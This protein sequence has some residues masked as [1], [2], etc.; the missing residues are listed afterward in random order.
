[1]RLKENQTFD[2]WMES[3]QSHEL[4][5]AQKKIDNGHSIELVLEELSNNITKKYM[6]FV[7]VMLRRAI[8]ESFNQ[9]SLERSKLAYEEKYLKN[10]KPRAD[11]VEDILFDN[12][13]KK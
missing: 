1:M 5:I 13:E 2:S 10:T 3:V 9:E 4:K 6:H 7:H 8:S 12:T 11:H